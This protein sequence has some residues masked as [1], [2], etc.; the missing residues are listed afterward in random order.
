MTGARPVEAGAIVTLT[1]AP[2]IDRTYAVPALGVGGVH[3]ATTVTEHLGGNG[4]NVTRALLAHQV[5]SAAVFPMR[6]TELAAL[7]DPAAA[8]FR[9][10]DLG[11]RTRVNTVVASADGVT[12]NVNERPAALAPGDWDRI[13]AVALRTAAEHG[14]HW[15]VVTGCLPGVAAGAGTVDLLPVVVA[16]RSTGIRVALD[17]PGHQLRDALDPLAPVDLVKPNRDEL[18]EATGLPVRSVAEVVSAAR[19]LLQHGARRALVTLGADGVLVVDASTAVLAPARDT[20]CV[21]TTGAGDAAL[22]GYLAARTAGHGLRAA[23]DQAAAWGAAAVSQHGAALRAT[24][25][26]TGALLALHDRQPAA[27]FAV[28][29]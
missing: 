17:V 11:T 26:T 3:R 12:T 5:G 13:A 19:A 8:A 16:A 10:V 9:N 25:A 18:H 22:A 1:P 21:D 2:A 23:A 7:A 27:A 28:A 15:L 29:S 6:T 24:P 14:A 20:R 4:V